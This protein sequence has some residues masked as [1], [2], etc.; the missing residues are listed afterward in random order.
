MTDNYGTARLDSG[1]RRGASSMLCSDDVGLRNP[2]IFYYILIGKNRFK[3]LAFQTNGLVSR[4]N[5]DGG[6]TTVSTD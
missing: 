4:A 6:T 5:R 3:R 1:S 2:F